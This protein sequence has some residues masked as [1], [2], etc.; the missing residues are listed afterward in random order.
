MNKQNRVLI[1][2]AAGMLGH[3]LFTQLS[4]QEGL[5][6]YATV[7]SEYGLSEWFSKELND[8]IIPDVDILNSDA[9]AK[10]LAAVEPDVVINCIGLVKQLPLAEDPNLAYAIN[11]EYPHKLASMCSS[12]NVR[13]IHFSTDCVFSGKLGN[14]SE[15]DVADP[16]DLYGK[17]KLLGEVTGSNC[18][19]IRTSII[20]H[21]LRGQNGLV[22]WFF[23]QKGKIRGYTHAIFSGFPTIEI[24]SILFNHVLP[25]ECLNGIVHVSSIPVSKYDLLML[26]ASQ[27]HKKIEI[28]PHENFRKDRSL[29]S[30]IFRSLTGYEPPQWPILID[31][32]YEHYMGTGLYCIP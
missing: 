18:I 21:E 24:A 1:F 23:A 31:R 3:V 19:T 9:I 12:S 6:V 2:G 15:T 29:N 11:A 32:M 10:A 16:E 30:N 4:E 5:N 14:Y 13:L 26:I 28:E 22:G 27:Y 8:K 20:G 7:R 25:N 17:T